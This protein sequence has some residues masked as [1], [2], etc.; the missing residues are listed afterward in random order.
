MNSSSLLSFLKNDL[1]LRIGRTAVDTNQNYFQSRLRN[2]VQPALLAISLLTFSLTAYLMYERTQEKY[3]KNRAEQVAKAVATTL[4]LGIQH[5]AAAVQSLANSVHDWSDLRLNRSGGPLVEN[6]Y[7]F[8]AVNKINRIGVITEVFPVEQNRSALNKNLFQRP[9]LA[10]YLEASRAENKVLMSH[11]IMTYQGIYA[12]TLYAPILDNNGKFLGWLN[13]VIDISS[14]IEGFLEELQFDNTRIDIEWHHPNYPTKTSFGPEVRDFYNYPTRIL[15]QDITIRIGFSSDALEAEFLRTYRLA[16]LMAIVLL[17][18][19]LALLIFA[20]LSNQKLKTA[21]AELSMKNSLLSALSHDLSNP[22]TTL[23][24]LFSSAIRAGSISEENK[25]RISHT[26][27]VMVEMLTNVKLL[28]AKDL[29]VVKIVTEPVMLLPTIQKAVQ[30]IEP[31]AAKKNVII[32]TSGVSERLK[33]LAH[34]PTLSNNVFMNVLINAV[35]FSPEGGRI[36]I[37]SREDDKRVRVIFEDQG[38]GLTPEQIENLKRSLFLLSTAGSQGETGTG[39]G[40]LQI[41]SFMAAYNGK[42]E[43]E[44]IGTPENPRGCRM[45]LIFKKP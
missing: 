41:R 17:V 5:R 14:L 35:K 32:D 45:I 23:S 26:L 20:H 36:T 13:A 15:N 22:L 38:P 8:Y 31:Y 3:F 27:K 29:G 34:G 10:P 28:H 1:F 12:F 19:A 42:I 6:I 44:N 24:L 4:R 39:L 33:V 9:E 43:A 16:I 25:E 21:N 2:W 37:A 7:G 18:A 11:Q 30:S 40:L